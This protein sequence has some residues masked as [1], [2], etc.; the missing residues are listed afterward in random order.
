MYMTYVIVGNTSNYQNYG[1]P[2]FL[3]TKNT[4]YYNIF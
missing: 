3:N 4:K 1:I 2:V